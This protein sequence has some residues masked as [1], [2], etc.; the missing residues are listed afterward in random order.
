MLTKRHFGNEQWLVGKYLNEIGIQVEHHQTKW[1]VFQRSMLEYQ[2][3][4]SRSA[5]AAGYLLNS[6]IMVR[7]L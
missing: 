3:V 1:G 5:L 7:I 4:N 2:S 6:P